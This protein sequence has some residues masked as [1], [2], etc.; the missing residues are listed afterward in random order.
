MRAGAAAPAAPAPRSGAAPA[1]GCRAGDHLRPADAAAG[2]RC[3]PPARGP[4]VY[5]HRAVLRDAGRPRRS[6]SSQTYLYYIQLQARSLPSHGQAGSRTTTTTEKTILDDFKR[7]WGTNFLDDLSVDVSDYTF[8]NGVDRQDRH[9]QHGGAAARQDRRLRRLEEG[10]AVEDRREAEGSERRRS[11]STRSSIPG[12][13]RQGRRHR[14][15]HA[16]G[17]GLP[18]RRGHA[19]RSRRSPAARSWCNL[20]FNIDEGPE[21]QDPRRS[22][23][24][25]TRRSATARC[26]AR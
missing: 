4:V 23:S 22:T 12:L 15:R 9:L 16:D 17:E 2:A 24:S 26:A 25:A 14:P 20:T 8:S 13:I 6:S 10:R 18:V 3:R 19:T 7:L 11:A 5:L 1:A 21:G